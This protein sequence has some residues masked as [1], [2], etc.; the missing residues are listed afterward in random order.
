[1]T[2][3][4]NNPKI[5]KDMTIGVAVEKYPAI[6]DPLME[7]GVHCVGCGAA[8]METLEQGLKGHGMSDDQVKDAM[9]K[10]NDAVKDIPEKKEERKVI[11]KTEN[12]DVVITGKA[13]DKLKEI[14][15]NEKK[16][17]YG[18][19][20]VVM[21]GG[22]SGYQYG[23]EFEKEAKEGDK[24]YVVN[25]AKFF[26]DGPSLEMLQ[27]SKI[28][29]HEGLQDSGFKIENPNANSTCGCGKSFN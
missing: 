3:V 9:V 25:G 1:K 24:T 19:R 28:D 13:A 4:E 2:E 18:L 20:I 22:C 29:Y 15:K 23:F 10:L 17:G 7:L 8:Y 11:G 5:T 12:M 26:V 16:E 27:G 14:M 6:V 21:P